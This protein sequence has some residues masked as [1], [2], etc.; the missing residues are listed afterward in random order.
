MPPLRA[1]LVGPHRQTHPDLRDPS[2]R[3]SE[4]VFD[5]RAAVSP[6]RS[7]TRN[8]H[9]EHSAGAP[10]GRRTS[11]HRPRRRLRHLSVAPRW[12]ACLRWLERYAAEVDGASL[13]DIQHIG[14]GSNS[15][16]RRLCL[17]ILRPME[18]LLRRRQLHRAADR[19][20]TMLVVVSAP[21]SR[22]G[23]QTRH[24]ATKRAGT[25]DADPHLAPSAAGG[26]S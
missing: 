11:A 24:A 20:T 12:P 13:G 2:R 9:G 19:P 10:R 4:H 1:P 17:G 6:S 22:V 15:S 26:A 16:S 5:G 18:R 7:S 14:P 8:P 3:E 23:K 25:S 21:R